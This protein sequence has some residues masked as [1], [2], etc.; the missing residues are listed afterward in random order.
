MTEKDASRREEW[1]GFGIGF[2]PE[3]R[4]PPGFAGA[5]RS[6]ERRDVFV[7]RIVEG[8]GVEGDPVREIVYWIDPDGWVIS[9]YDA[10]E[11]RDQR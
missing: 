11:H 1:I 5:L 3:G 2:E 7:A 4:R 9:R 10:W 8:E 6:F